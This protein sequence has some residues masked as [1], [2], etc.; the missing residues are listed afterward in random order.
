[1]IN[2]L[3]QFLDSSPVN[4]LAVDTI[5]KRLNDAGFKCFDSSSRCVRGRREILCCEERFFYL[6]FRDW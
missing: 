3:F 4:F 1:M 6:C 2:R 5:C